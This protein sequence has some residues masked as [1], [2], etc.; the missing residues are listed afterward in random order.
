M[1][2]YIRKSLY[3]RK[4]NILSIKTCRRKIYMNFK[5]II[6]TSIFLLILSIGAI[7]AADLNETNSQTS[8]MDN[9]ISISNHVE[10]NNTDNSNKGESP[11]TFEDLQRK[12]DNARAGSVLDLTRDYI[13]Q[14]GLNIVCNKFL[15]ID[16]HGHTIDCQ[17]KKGCYGFYSESG[18]IIL[19][20]LRIINGNSNGNGGAICSEK[21]S[22][23]LI[24]NC[25]FENNFAKNCGGAIFSNMPLVIEHSKFI[26]NTANQQG[27]A[28]YCSNFV[29][30]ENC[31][32]E[33]N[34]AV[35]SDGG[36]IYS[37]ESV[38]LINSTLN[39]NLCGW[40]GGAVY[41]KTSVVV[42]TCQISSN[43]AKG[44]GKE[45]R[46]GAIRAVKNVEVIN[47]IFIGNYVNNFGGAIYAGTV[48]V[49]PYETIVSFTTKFLNN[50]AEVDG[51]AIYSEGLTI[52]NYCILEGNGAYNSGGAIFCGNSIVQNSRII[53]NH[54]KNGYGGG[55]YTL[56]NIKVDNCS[57]D[58]NQAS[59]SGGAINTNSI[60]FTKTNSF[61][62]ENSAYYGAGGAIWTQEITNTEVSN[63]VFSCNG[64]GT[65][66][67]DSDY[68][69]D[70]GCNGGAIYIGDKNSVTFSGCTFSGNYAYNKGGAI[71]M[72]TRNSKISIKNNHFDG[73]HVGIEEG[74]GSCIYTY[75]KYGTIY[76]NFWHGSKP[77]SD[78]DVL[79]EWIPLLPNKH[80]EDTDPR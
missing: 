32:F 12:V 34:T 74:E 20:N 5:Y 72:D 46:G 40:S 67:S 18:Q 10:Q 30:C 23:Y 8:H 7:S 33:R 6:L 9:S 50:Y 52:T 54:A 4:F 26:S 13:G 71:Y 44:N 49:N 73:N 79:I 24:I 35:N 75:G 62:H 60:T 11:G 3:I 27:G 61:F 64:A 57:F 37:K 77:T 29:D 28:I 42:D 1:G 48:N 70:Y 16:G 21:N 14:E 17:G 65:K 15:I 31:Q 80:H 59:E 2:T 51:G 25:T 43:S 22:R 63:M 66:M 56:H 53:S 39:N 36:A 45:S 19:K 68:S 55:I 47:S 41:S 78:N 69:D 38:K 58:F 76:N